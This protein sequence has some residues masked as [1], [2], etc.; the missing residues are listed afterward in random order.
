M[1]DRRKDATTVTQTLNARV[2]N[3][4]PFQNAQDFE[5]AKR[6]LIAPLPHNGVIYSHSHVDRYGGVRGI[7]CEEDVKA[8][9]VKI[10]APEGFLDAAI[11]ENVLAGN[12]MSRRA[13][14]MY[15]NLLAVDAK[16]QVGVGLGMTTST[17]TITLIPPTHTITYTGE[18]MKIDGLDC[19]FTIAPDSEVLEQLGYQSE[20][21]PWRNFYLTGA[22]ELWEG[23]KK[24]PGAGTAS[25]DTVKAMS[26]S[27]LFD[28]L[29]VRLNG[30]KAAGK[31][32]VF[33][34]NFTDTQEQY[35][36][37]LENT[38]LTHQPDRQVENADTTLTLTRN[39]MNKI[40]L[41]EST[42]AKEIAS[43]KVKIQ[44]SVDALSELVSLLDT[45]EFW[46]NIVEP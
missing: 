26:M 22:Q 15:G 11:A 43:G 42:L 19:E 44:G 8:G 23:V 33:N 6:G 46:F 38:A 40:I 32:L 34:L 37:N 24:L 25:P 28:Y 3:K 29:G 45:F 36:L 14:Y 18:K 35:V 21:G 27:L 20:S 13:S 9:K 41:R 10:V 5:D 31:K 12:V 30:E 7:V 2:L 1:S 17:G 39:A 16:G 4:L